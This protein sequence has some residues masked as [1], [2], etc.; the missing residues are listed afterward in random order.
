MS[1]DTQVIER[2]TRVET[3]IDNFLMSMADQHERIDDHETRLRG[4]EAGSSRL[5]GMGIL[6]A[7]L[8]SI[9]GSRLLS[10]LTGT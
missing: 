2:L 10:L 4:L 9:A 7:T 8:G 1:N 6:L 3:K 5:L